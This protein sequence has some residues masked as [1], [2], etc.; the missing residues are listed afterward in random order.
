VADERGTSEPAVIRMVV[1]V[2][3]GMPWIEHQPRAP[4][5]QRSPGEWD[6]MVAGTGSQDG[7]RSY[8]QRWSERDPRIHLVRASARRAAAGGTE[9]RSRR[10]AAACWP[11]VMPR[12]W[13]AGLGSLHAGAPCRRQSGCRGIRHRRTGG[14]PNS[15]LVHAATRQLG[16]LPFGLSANAAVPREVFDGLQGFDEELSPEEDVDL[17]WRLQLEG[18]RFAPATD[19]V[20]E[21][22]ERAGGLPTF[23]GAWA[24]GRCGPRPYVRCRAEGMRRDL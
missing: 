9:H 21:K 2:R 6:V 22:R 23:R 3:N 8:V 24:D 1:P 19:A 17:C 4:S 5:T 11:S 14:A 16:F 10:P 7:T 20:V 12:T 15:F 18:H 13:C